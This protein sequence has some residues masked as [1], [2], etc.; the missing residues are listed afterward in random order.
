[1]TIRKVAKSW[2]NLVFTLPWWYLGIVSMFAYQVDWLGI[3]TT[4]FIVSAILILGAAAVILKCLEISLTHEPLLDDE[5][6][7]GPSRAAQ[8]R[9]NARR[10][11]R[12]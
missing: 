1:M 6:G 3:S 9:E 12:K 2:L 10:G 4:G 8:L 5:S 11:L 7:E